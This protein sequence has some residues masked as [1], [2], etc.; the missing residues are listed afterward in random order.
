MPFRYASFETAECSQELDAHTAQ[1][2]IF[3]DPP[4]DHRLGPAL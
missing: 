2:I 4:T 1:L 3:N